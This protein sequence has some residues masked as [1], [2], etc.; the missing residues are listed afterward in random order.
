MNIREY[1]EADRPF[2]RTLYL[3]S[4]QAAFSWI[5]QENFRLEDFDKAVL[6]EKILVAV[7]DGNR[8]GFASVFREENFLHNLFVDPSSQGLGVGKLLLQAV[9]RELTATGVLKCLVRNQ[10]ALAFYQ[11]NGWQKIATGKGEDGE[12]ILMHW[13]KP[14]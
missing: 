12:Y 4:R 13:V 1:Q 10:R 7:E 5:N 6:G 11:Q 8:L 2:L 3:A 14:S 9:Q